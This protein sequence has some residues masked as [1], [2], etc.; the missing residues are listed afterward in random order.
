MNYNNIAK[1]Y[2]ELYG[3][4]Q[5]K[6]ARLILE[7]INLNKT[8]LLLDVGCGTGISTESFKCIKIGIDPSEELIKQAIKRI[9]AI[10]GKGEKLPFSD[11]IFDLVVSLTAIHNFEDFKQGIKEM[12][13]VCKKDGMI[14]I[15]ILKKSAKSE[16]IKKEIIKELKLIKEIDEEKDIISI[17]QTL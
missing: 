7:N 10:I 11:N 17:T 4:E 6:K 15:T 1:G 9:P 8:D 14:I 2:D 5:K 13:R 16:A 12:K 3:E